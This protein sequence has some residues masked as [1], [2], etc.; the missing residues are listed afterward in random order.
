MRR[1]KAARLQEARQWVDKLLED[2]AKLDYLL[3]TTRGIIETEG[4]FFGKGDLITDV[5][6]HMARDIERILTQGPPEARD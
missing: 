3:E 2:Q 6:V 5:R 4:P 1:K